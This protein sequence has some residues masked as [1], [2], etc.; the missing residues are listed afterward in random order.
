MM[1]IGRNFLV[2]KDDRKSIPGTGTA[3]AMAWR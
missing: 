2:E 3:Q 1:K